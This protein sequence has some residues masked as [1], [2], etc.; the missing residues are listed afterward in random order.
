MPAVS[1][2]CVCVWTDPDIGV[3]VA[4]ADHFPAPGAHDV[5]GGGLAGCCVPHSSTPP[6]PPPSHLFPGECQC[7]TVISLP[8]GDDGVI[9]SLCLLGYDVA[10]RCHVNGQGLDRCGRWEA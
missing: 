8:T 5:G 7:V 1:C 9:L 10:G 6:S 3:P 2:V 4:S